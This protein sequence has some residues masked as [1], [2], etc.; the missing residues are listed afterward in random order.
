MS[1]YLD[2]ASLVLI[3]M[4]SVGVWGSMFVAVY[5]YNKNYYMESKTEYVQEKT[6]YL[7]EKRKYENRLNKGKSKNE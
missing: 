5:Y 3:S 1:M 4:V 6:K 2:I 7:R